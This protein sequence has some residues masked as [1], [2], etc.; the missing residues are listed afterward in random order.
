MTKGAL[1]P[2]C[3]TSNGRLKLGG[4]AGQEGFHEQKGRVFLFCSR[5]G[6]NSM[7]KAGEEQW[8]GPPH[9]TLSRRAS[10]LTRTPR[11]IRAH[12][13]VLN[14]QIAVNVITSKFKLLA[15]S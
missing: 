5:R 6:G 12:M 8:V 1:S 14:E 13:S 4:L 7:M 9:G 11:H 15:Q 2:L 10:Q 3:A